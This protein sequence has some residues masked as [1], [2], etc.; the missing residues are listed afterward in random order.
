MHILRIEVVVDHLCSVRRLAKHSLHQDGEYPDAV[1][2]ADRRNT[3]FCC[4]PDQLKT[5]TL[6]QSSKLYTAGVVHQRLLSGF[7][8]SKPDLGPGFI[9][10]PEQMG[11]A[12]LLRPT[13]EQVS[14]DG[15]E[16]ILAP[17]HRKGFH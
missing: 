11:C 15:Q 2:S 8:A 3:R 9:E 17:V 6:I 1:P 4:M 12:I 14:M 13:D 10:V 16:K 5:P 7:H